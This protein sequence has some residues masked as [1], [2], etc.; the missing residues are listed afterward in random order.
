[1]QKRGPGRKGEFDSVDKE[2]QC[3]TAGQAAHGVMDHAGNNPLGQKER[4][5][6]RRSLWTLKLTLV[7]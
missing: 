5:L 4:K 3:N 7:D 2:E 6:L 1:M